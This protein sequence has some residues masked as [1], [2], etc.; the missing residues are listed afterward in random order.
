MKK[1]KKLT[2]VATALFMFTAPAMAQE[3]L[4][5]AQ[6]LALVELGLGD[7]AIIAKIN[8]SDSQYDLSVD[9]M[10]ALKNKGVSSPVIAAMIKS[11]DKQNEKPPEFFAKSP[12]PNLPHPAGVYLLSD[13]LD[14]PEMTKINY[15]VSNQVK[16]GGFLGAALTGGIASTSLKAV[17]PNDSAL[18]DSKSKKPVFYMFF[19]ESNPSNN[20]NA[21]SWSSGDAAIVTSPSEFTLISLNVK[22]GK[23]EAKVGKFNFTGAKTGVLDKDQL[24]FD[25]EEIRRG[26]YKV[27]TREELKPG[28][29]GFIFAISGD[30]GRGVASARVFDFTVL[31]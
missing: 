27:T 2:L 7:E 30:S 15:T 26:V 5:N 13:W 22:K 17:I 1:F 10:L 14:T 11:Q 4:D 28:E 29:Y 23:R 9:N 6:V 12:D 18:I 3:K 20:V 21:S 8:S 19:D 31:K 25:Y 24:A 16:T